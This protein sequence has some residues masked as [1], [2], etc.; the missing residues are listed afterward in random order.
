MRKRNA[1]LFMMGDSR[2]CS[3]TNGNDCVDGKRRDNDRSK[4]HRAV[5]GGDE[6]QKRV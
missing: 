2:L 3:Y 5:T 4:S 1:F 6:I